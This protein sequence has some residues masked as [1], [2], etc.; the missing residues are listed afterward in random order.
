MKRSLLLRMYGDHH[1]EVS[2][3][4]R[5]QWFGN[6]GPASGLQIILCKWLEER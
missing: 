3:H 2:P 1:I 6:K 5:P 4:R